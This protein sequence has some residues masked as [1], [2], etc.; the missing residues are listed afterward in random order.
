MLAQRVDRIRTY[1]QEGRHLSHGRD[2]DFE[3][4]SGRRR[5]KRSICRMAQLQNLLGQNRF[6][7]V[8]TDNG[9]VQY[10]L[11]DKSAAKGS[12]PDELSHMNHHQFHNEYLLNLRKPANEIEGIRTQG[13]N[14]L[15]KET[16]GSSEGQ[17]KTFSAQRKKSLYRAPPQVFRSKESMCNAYQCST[18]L[19]IKNG[20]KL[21]HQM[22]EIGS[23]CKNGV[24][25]KKLHQQL[26]MESQNS[27]GT[28]LA[29]ESDENT[30]ISPKSKTRVLDSLKISEDKNIFNENLMKNKQND[31]MRS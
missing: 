4:H 9:T 11:V 31:K 21:N 29:S 14:Y 30:I 24:T 18:P 20:R 16:I 15:K 3:D 7:A 27:V 23:N 13:R 5:V 26:T 19:Y 12:Q 17:Q 10:R 2:K 25:R 6:S 1:I 22:P 28:R 8:A